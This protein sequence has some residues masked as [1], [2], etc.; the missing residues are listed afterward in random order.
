M[1]LHCYCYVAECVFFYSEALYM[2]LINAKKFGLN[3]IIS[4]QPDI[5]CF[6]VMFEKYILI[7]C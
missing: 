6:H 2:L 1:L 4:M 7:D 5:N 3:E